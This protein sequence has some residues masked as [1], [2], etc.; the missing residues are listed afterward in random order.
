MHK[1]MSMLIAGVMLLAG[2]GVSG[3]AA[4]P[5]AM[6][7]D[8]CSIPPDALEATG[9][10]PSYS[11]P[12]FGD[13]VVV[14]DWSLCTFRGPT[15]NPSYF[16]NVKSSETHTLDEAR[17]NDSHL[18]GF[19]LE[20]GGRDGFQFNTALSRSITNCAIA[21]I[22]G[23]GV[24]VFSVDSMGTKEIGF[25]PCALVMEHTTDLETFLPPA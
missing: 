5:A 19:D 9:L 13:G 21:V 2:C 3:E 25:A 8:P 6:R 20:V 22:S 11:S 23:P 24:V 17:A 10:D 15:A 7:W 12:G 1:R 18:N 14:P 4:A 16:F